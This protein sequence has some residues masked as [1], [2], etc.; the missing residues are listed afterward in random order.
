MKPPFPHKQSRPRQQAAKS[1]WEPVADWYGD[2]LKSEG[3]L[4][5]TVVYPNALRLL[6]P[7]EGG[8]YLDIAAGEGSFTRL[9]ARTPKSTVVGF[10]A[11]PSLIEHAKSQAPKKGTEY[12]VLDARDFASHF[13]AQS[14][15]GA[16]CLLAIQNIDDVPAVF[17]D[18][19][20][21]LKPGG[22][23]VIVMNHP[24]FRIPRQS[25]WDYD[26]SKKLMARRIDRYLTPLDIPIFTRPGAAAG[27]STTSYLR[28][29]S[30]AL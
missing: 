23:F 15:D 17:R 24:F 26:E 16:S 2:H 12:S 22:S 1:G 18:A 11:A 29:L 28:S 20:R 13:P 30:Q 25:A 7:K 5:K 4:L 3:S 6:A 21:I 9:I 14:F 27:P 8:Y 10:D 19:A